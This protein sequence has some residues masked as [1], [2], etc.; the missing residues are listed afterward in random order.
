MA[1][2]NVMLPDG[3]EQTYRDIETVTYDSASVEGG[4]E[5]FVSERLILNQAQSDWGQ[6]DPTQPDYV[7]N[8]PF[9]SNI[10]IGDTVM[11]LTMDNMSIKSADIAE[12]LKTNGMYMYAYDIEEAGIDIKIEVGKTYAFSLGDKVLCAK[13]RTYGD[14]W[15][16]YAGNL[17]L[18]DKADE[19]FGGVNNE[20]PDTGEVFLLAPNAVEIGSPYGSIQFISSN[21]YGDNVTIFISE[22]TED[23]TKI[24]RKYIPEIPLF[25]LVALGL[26]AVSIDDSASS[27][28][29]IAC[30]TSNIIEALSHGLV[31]FKIMISS[32]T[33]SVPFVLTMTP[34][35][36]LTVFS[37]VNMI[38]YDD[39]KVATI[40]IE[41]TEGHIAA[42]IRVLIPQTM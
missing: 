5:T 42:R 11:E 1:D 16:L 30:D 10:N 33:E 20:Y 34:V 31:N 8:K 4:T 26:P 39:F 12:I 38:M 21:D 15:P 32:G 19:L 35:K 40:H 37:C 29:S 13:A 9:D 14:K 28:V 41:V 6:R 27:D 23:V 2:I 17:S 3:S 25:N 7:K 22:A 24:E 18:Y 36:V